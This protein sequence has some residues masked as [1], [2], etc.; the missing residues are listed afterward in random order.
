[1]KEQGRGTFVP[2]QGGEVRLKISDTVE[3]S[4]RK[5]KGGAQGEER[6]PTENRAGGEKGNV[7]PIFRGEKTT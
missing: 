1:M 4:Y 7:F 2:S 3:T 6:K 5:G